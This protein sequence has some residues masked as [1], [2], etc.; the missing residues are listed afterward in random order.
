MAGT[1]QGQDRDKTGTRLGIGR[2]KEGK[3]GGGG[4]LEGGEVR[5]W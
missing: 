1:E 2:A 3:K 4:V 5:E